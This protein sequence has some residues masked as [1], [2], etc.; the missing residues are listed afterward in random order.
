VGT[1]ISNADWHYGVVMSGDSNVMANSLTITNTGAAE[2]ALPVNSTGSAIELFGVTGSTFTS[3]HASG[4]P[5]YGLAIARSTDDTFD[6][7]IIARD[8]RGRS[9]PGINIDHDSAGNTFQYASVTDTSVGVNLGG[10]GAKL[11]PSSRTG[12]VDNTF[13]LLVLVGDTYSAV[14]VGGGTGNV[15]VTIDATDVGGGYP[16]PDKASIRLYNTGTSN[17]RIE[18]Y[19]AYFNIGFAKWDTADYLVYADAN[20]SHN[21]VHFGTI[22]GGYSVARSHDANG[23]NNFS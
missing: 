11:D 2:G 10:G 16:A 6:S 15:F 1:F 19:N 23:T 13:D 22:E 7:V 14:N 5:G 12:N 20:A 8:G 18:D 17:N 4:M 3:I 21:S 9:N